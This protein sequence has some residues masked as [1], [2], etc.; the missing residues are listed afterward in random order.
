MKEIDLARFS[1]WLNHS[2]VV[3]YY[4]LLGFALIMAVFVTL[5][6]YI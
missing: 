5:E 6:L 4:M 2:K 3:R 1:R